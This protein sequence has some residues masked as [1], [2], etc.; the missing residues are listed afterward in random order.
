MADAG[1]ASS[2]TQA[3]L[4]EDFLDIFYAPSDVFVRRRDRSG[5][6][7]LVIVTVVLGL[8]FFAWQSSLRPIMALEMDRSMAEAMAQNPEVDPGQ[9]ETMRSMGPTMALV[10]FVLAFPVGVIVTAAVT[11]G[12]ARV[13][14]AAASFGTALMVVSYAQVV[15]VLGFVGGLIQSTVFGVE[16]LDSVHDVGFSLARFIDQPEAESMVVALA[17][18][19]DLFTIWATAL[20]AIGLQATTQLTRFQA[21][22][23]AGLVWLLAAVPTLAGGLMGG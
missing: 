22:L 3:A 15:R 5:W 20:I 11:W 18:R 10:G 21:W 2:D 17:A 16:G 23:V 19:V 6:L 14:G 12:L 8:L 4:W 13:F 1:N 7:V 9:F